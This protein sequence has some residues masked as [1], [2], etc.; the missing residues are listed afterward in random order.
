MALILVLSLSIFRRRTRTEKDDTN[1]THAKGGKD[2]IRSEQRSL[3]ERHG[4]LRMIFPFVN[5][6][7]GLVYP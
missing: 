4:R 7:Q 1:N 3:G 5:V 2:L 6:G